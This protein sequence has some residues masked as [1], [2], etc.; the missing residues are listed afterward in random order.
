M[1]FQ[2]K[3]VPLAAQKSECAIRT[4]DNLG[5][6]T[7]FC[8]VRTFDLASLQHHQPGG[9]GVFRTRRDHVAP[10]KGAVLLVDDSQG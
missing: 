6:R 2:M 8:L 10:Y 4:C 3:L 1:R 5:H 9:P 7:R